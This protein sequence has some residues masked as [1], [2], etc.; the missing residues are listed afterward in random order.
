[1]SASHEA[2]FTKSSNVAV[3]L[4]HNGTGDEGLLLLKDGGTTT[5]QIYGESGQV[6]FF[7]AGNLGINETN[8]QRALHIGSGGTFRFERGDGTRYG[9]LWNDNSFVAVSYTHLTLPTKRIV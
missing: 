7:N 8:P 3:F 6:S 9:E 5:I 4:G 2:H 1:M